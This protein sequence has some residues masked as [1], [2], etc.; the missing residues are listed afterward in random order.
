[1]T[2]MCYLGDSSGGA[3]PRLGLI[4]FGSLRSVDGNGE[5]V[6]VSRERPKDPIGP[7]K[8]PSPPTGVTVGSRPLTSEPLGNTAAAV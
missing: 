3:S 2:K 7:L 4:A 5:C 8:V 6:P 1:M